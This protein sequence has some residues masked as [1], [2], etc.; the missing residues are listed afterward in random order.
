M[1]FAP[2]RNQ[3]LRRVA[4]RYPK[5]RII[6]DHLGLD[7]SLRDGEIDSPVE[8]VLQLSEFGNVAVKAS[9]LPSYVSDD[10]PF[11]SLHGTIEKVVD[12]FGPSR[13]LWGSDLSRLRCSY[14]EAVQ[15]FTSSVTFLSQ[16]DKEWIMGKAAAKW[17]NWE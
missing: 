8:S 2:N 9:S 10:F 5:L 4:E 11:S 14:E 7:T 6:I 1:V 16:E 17:L 3:T 15:L 12:A 13:V